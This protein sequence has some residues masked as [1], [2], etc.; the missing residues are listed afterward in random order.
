MTASYKNAAK[1]VE[2]TVTSAAETLGETA[3]DSGKIAMQ[4]LFIS[5]TTVRSHVTAILTKLNVANRTQAALVAQER[6]LV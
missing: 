2:G 3:R 1:D 4:A 5:A 6:Q